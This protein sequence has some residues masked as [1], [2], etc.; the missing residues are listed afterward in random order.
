MGGRTIIFRFVI[1][2]DSIKGVKLLDIRVRARQTDLKW[3]VD[4]EKLSELTKNNQVAKLHLD[5][6]ILP[7]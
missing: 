3:H 5:F 6:L 4:G 2:L 7:N 1:F